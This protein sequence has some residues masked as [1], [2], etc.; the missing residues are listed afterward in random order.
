MHVCMCASET[1]VTWKPLITFPSKFYTMILKFFLKKP[2]RPEFRG[3]FCFA[4]KWTQWAENSGVFWEKK[5]FF[6]FFWK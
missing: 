6:S 4:Q 2:I 3:T 5:S 1:S